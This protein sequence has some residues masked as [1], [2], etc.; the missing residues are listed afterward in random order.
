M[1]MQMSKLPRSSRVQ[2]FSFRF[3]RAARCILLL[4]QLGPAKLASSAA[5]RVAGRPR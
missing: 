4:R 1:T 3:D 5:P 2:V